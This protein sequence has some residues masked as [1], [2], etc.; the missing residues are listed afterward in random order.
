MLN[1]GAGA[2]VL[3][4]P[5]NPRPSVPPPGQRTDGER[6]PPNPRP[7]ALMAEHRTVKIHVRVS[8]A[9]HAA[10]RAKAEAGP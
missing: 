9:E 3:R 2:G 6:R 10:R 1:I 4:P 5:S 8:P 7:G